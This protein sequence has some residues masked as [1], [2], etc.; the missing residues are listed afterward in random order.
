VSWWDNALYD[1]CSLITLDKL[2]LDHPQ[3][4]TSFPSVLTVEHC[5]SKDNMRA[6]TATRMRSRVSL[7]D[8]PPLADVARILNTAQLSKRISE[9]D[10]L[11]YVTGIHFKITVVTGDVLLAKILVAERIQT[12]N[13]ALVLKDMVRNGM[14][15]PQACTNV[16]ADLARRNDYLL[17]PKVPQTWASL[18]HHT[19]P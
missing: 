10:K 3:L 2:L 15:S 12:G 5:I 8:L 6:A 17:S 16:L 11:I 18:R 1:T 7:Q 14:M 9:V 4:A 19:F 13:M